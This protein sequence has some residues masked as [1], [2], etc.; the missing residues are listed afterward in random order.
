V[1][2]SL[3]LTSAGVAPTGTDLTTCKAI[4]DRGIRQFLYPIDKKYGTPHEWS[5]IKQYWSFS[6]IGGKWK[7][8][9]PIDFS[10]ALTGFSYEDS[11]ALKPLEEISAQQIKEMRS[12]TVTSGWPVYYA[13]VPQRYDVE[14]GTTYELW[15]YPN[16]SQVYTFSCFY[17]IDPVKLAA[18]TDF[19]IGGVMATEAILESCLGVAEHQ[20]DDNDT[21]HHQDKANELIQAAIRF[22]SAKADTDTIGNLHTGKNLGLDTNAG[23]GVCTRFAY[24]NQSDIYAQG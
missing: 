13:I 18:T 19:A 10:D 20:E 24:V 21:T 9:L 11:Q 1:S 2:N 15:L 8:S 6:T 16:P 7:Y 17:R 3:G 22:D 23:G 5:F 4:V 12:Y 14:L